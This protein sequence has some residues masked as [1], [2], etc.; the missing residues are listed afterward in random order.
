ML[1]IILAITGALTLGYLVFMVSLWIKIIVRGESMI[2]ARPFVALPLVAVHLLL[3]NSLKWILVVVIVDTIY[4]CV[5]TISELRKRR[6]AEEAELGLQSLIQK[7]ETSD[8]FITST[9]NEQ[10]PCGASSGS[11]PPVDMTALVASRGIYVK[12]RKHAA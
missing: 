7:L 11:R 5:V 3:L 6:A 8:S 12:S 2:Y 1:Q 4:L 9:N 10:A